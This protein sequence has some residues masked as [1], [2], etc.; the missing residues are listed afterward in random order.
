MEF[1]SNLGGGLQVDRPSLFELIAQDKMREMLEPALRYV[2]AVYAQRYPRYLIRIVNRYEE[3]YAIL[4]F[5]V[6]RHYLREYGASFAENFYGLKRVRAPRVVKQHKVNIDEDSVAAA[7]AAVKTAPGSNKLRETDIRKSLLFLIGLPYIKCKLDEY[8][9]KISGG[10]AARL[11]GDEFAQEEEDLTGQPFTVRSKAKAIKI[12]KMGYP[13]VNA[14]YQL[15]I[16]AHYIGYLYNKTAFYSPWLR[17]IGI[18]VKRMSAADYREILQ[19]AKAPKRTSNSL[20]ESIQNRVLGL[21][22]G[23][24]DFLKVLLPMSIFFF[25]FLEWWY[26]S[27]YY[28]KSSTAGDTAEVPPPERVKPHPEGLALPRAA[29]VCP[30]CLKTITNPTALSSGYVYCYPCA[31]KQVEDHGRCPVTLIGCKTDDLRKLYNDAGM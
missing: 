10:E 15:S 3:F 9:E 28:R 27:D 18:E 4:M 16:L 24:L 21:L 29:N 1:M 25:K 2:I 23:S 20:M 12:F 7:A 13:Y 14:L 22:S 8:Y 19:K 30:I 26:Q 5:F 17:I 6:E 31:Y 11:F